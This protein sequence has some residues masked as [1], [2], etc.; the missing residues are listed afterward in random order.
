MK[1]TR[2]KI[3]I[4]RK[5][6][7]I[8]VIPLALTLALILSACGQNPGTGAAS[9]ATPTTAP[10]VVKTPGAYGCPSGVVTNAPTTPANV[11]VEFKNSNGTVTARSGDVIEFRLPFGQMWSGPTTSQ[12]VLQL[13][14]PSGYAM[15]AMKACIWRFVAVS[16]GTTQVNFMG[17]AICKKGQMCPQYILRVPFTVEVK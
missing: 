10:T 12:G 9:G 14:T 1:K 16:S 8:F 4:I 5:H 6:S 17:R 3:H 11:V 2:D 13:Q 15:T 7:I